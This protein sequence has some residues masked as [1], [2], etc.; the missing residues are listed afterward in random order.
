MIGKDIVMLPR[1]RLCRQEHPWSCG[2]AAVRTAL[3][4]LGITTGL[5]DRELH[6]LADNH[7]DIHPGTCPD[8]MRQIL[9][10][11]D[12]G[13]HE[14]P[15]EGFSASGIRK[16]ISE[17]MPVIAATSDWGGHWCVLVGYAED[18]MDPE[19]DILIVA[20][21]YP[22]LEHITPHLQLWTADRLISMADMGLFFPEGHSRRKN[23]L[24]ALERPDT[25]SGMCSGSLLF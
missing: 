5:S 11:F 21:P 16:A 24:F 14:A 9:E 7:E 2:P 3:G 6:S 25:A 15:A 17:G 23:A 10:H 19:K 12:I 1:L 18:G 4:C 13:I 22:A 8:Q 20:D